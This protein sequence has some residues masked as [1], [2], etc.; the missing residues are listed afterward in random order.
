MAFSQ[1]HPRK[2][3]KHAS[4][5]MVGMMR[6]LDLIARTLDTMQEREFIPASRKRE[7]AK[8]E[9]DL[10]M[11]RARYAKEILEY[12]VVKGDVSKFPEVRVRLAMMLKIPDERFLDTV[13][14]LAHVYERRYHEL[15]H[16]AIAKEKQWKARD[17]VDLM[18]RFTK[19]QFPMA[20]GMTA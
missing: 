14:E 1:S 5:K 4:D 8:R 15:A 2:E 16:G 3:L 19:K 18:A 11:E 17:K 7:I 20:M 12:W 13:D 10:M 6:D 9:H